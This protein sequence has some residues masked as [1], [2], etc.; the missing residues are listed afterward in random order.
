[1]YSSRRRTLEALSDLSE[2]EL[3]HLV[4]TITLSPTGSVAT[5]LVE[6][7]DADFAHEGNADHCYGLRGP[8]GIKAERVFEE[9][10]KRTY[11]PIPGHL[12]DRRY[13]QRGFDYEIEGS[14]TQFM[15]R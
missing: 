11:E 8:T 15:W 4:K 3:F 2:T 12:H 5:A 6:A 14:S 13:Q 9:F 10:H 1:M 7:I